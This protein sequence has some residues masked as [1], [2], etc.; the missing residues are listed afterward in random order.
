MEADSEC[1]KA[2]E[3]FRRSR[4]RPFPAIT[5]LTTTRTA[6]YSRKRSDYLSQLKK[7]TSK[8]DLQRGPQRRSPFQLS[9]STQKMVYV[10][11]NEIVGSTSEN[12]G[13][14]DIILFG[15][16]TVYV[17]FSSFSEVSKGRWPL[18]KKQSRGSGFE[19]RGFHSR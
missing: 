11:T 7:A 2:M 5:Q 12:A 8:E 9:R 19:G 3:D 13:P 1:R 18:R 10:L 14:K 6:S 17:L 16:S 15:Y 4:P